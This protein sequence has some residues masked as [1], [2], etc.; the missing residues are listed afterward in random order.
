MHKNLD[1]DTS[2]RNGKKPDKLFNKRKKREE[3]NEHVVLRKKRDLQ[4]T[5][6][7][8]TETIRTM[9]NSDVGLTVYSLVNIIHAIILIL[10]ILRFEEGS[11]PF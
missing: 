4:D 1:E 5:L 10:I 2:T 6:T 8:V 11:T 3:E 7:E 9:T